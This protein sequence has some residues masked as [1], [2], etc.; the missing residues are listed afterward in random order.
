M[1]LGHGPAQHLIKVSLPYINGVSNWESSG[2][3]LRQKYTQRYLRARGQSGLVICATDEHGNAGG[4]TAGRTNGLTLRSSAAFSR[5]SG[6]RSGLR[7][8]FDWFGRRRLRR[9][10]S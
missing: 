5:R 8:L 4:G 2:S 1:A 9:I 3:M 7:F 6:P 10:T